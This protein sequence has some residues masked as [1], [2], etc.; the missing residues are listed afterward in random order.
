M[1]DPRLSRDVRYRSMVH[2]PAM[3]SVDDGS[4][5]DHTKMVDDYPVRECLLTVL[6][7]EWERRL[8]AE[9]DLDALTERRE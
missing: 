6:N 1:L 9:R 4:L 5:F 3:S 8:Y 7:E 2:V